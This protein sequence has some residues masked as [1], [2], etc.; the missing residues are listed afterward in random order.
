MLVTLYRKHLRRILWEFSRTPIF[1][2]SAPNVSP[3]CPRTSIWLVVSVESAL[4]EDLSSNVSI[5]FNIS[6]MVFLAMTRYV[7]SF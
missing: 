2:L 1:A 6:Y 3:L 4:E 7:L 5:V